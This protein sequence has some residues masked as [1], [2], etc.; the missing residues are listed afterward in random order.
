MKYEVDFLDYA[1]G[2]TSP[3]DIID[4]RP[5]YTPDDYVADC[6]EN[7]DDDWNQMLQGG[8]VILTEIMTHELVVVWDDGSQQVYPYN[9]REEAEQGGENMKFALGNQVKWY[10]V[11]ERN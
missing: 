7:A 5:G 10:G 6:K 3:I 2:A 1:N 9:S 4:A 8:M 11:R